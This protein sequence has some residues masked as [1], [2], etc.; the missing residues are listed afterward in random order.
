MWYLKGCRFEQ[1]FS[2]TI[3]FSIEDFVVYDI[4]YLL[5]IVHTYFETNPSALRR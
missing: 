4:N 2:L 5:Y 3:L 1:P